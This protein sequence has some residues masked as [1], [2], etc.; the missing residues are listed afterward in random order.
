MLLTAALPKGA[1]PA[2]VSQHV[3]LTETNNPIRIATETAAAEYDAPWTV[4]GTVGAPA[5]EGP[6]SYHLSLSWSAQGHPTTRVFAGTA[7]E[8]APTLSIPDSTKL[9]GWSVR[10]I[11]TR[12][13]PASAGGAGPAGAAAGVPAGVTTV[14]ELRRLP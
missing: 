13:G 6:V 7:S 1:P 3:H 9:A 12:Q 11:G 14:G 10:A 8:A 4:D 5:V 2:G